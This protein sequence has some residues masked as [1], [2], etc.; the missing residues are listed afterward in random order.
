MTEDRLEQAGLPATRAQTIPAENK[1]WKSNDLFGESNEIEIIHAG[2]LYRLRIT[3]QGKL[4]L[5][6]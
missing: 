4:I 5:N 3:R 6:K 2:A 1:R